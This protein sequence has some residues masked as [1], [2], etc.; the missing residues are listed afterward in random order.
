MFVRVAFGFG[1][2][3]AHI[4]SFPCHW[5]QTSPP[6][7]LLIF[8][9]LLSS[10]RRR[11]LLAFGIRRLPRAPPTSSSPFCPQEI[12]LRTTGLPVL[13][14]NWAWVVGCSP[15]VSWDD[16]FFADLSWICEKGE[17]FCSCFNARVGVGSGDLSFVCV[18][19]FFGMRKFC[20]F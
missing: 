20:V 19:F 14:L 16:R 10:D 17:F 8:F 5:P 6:P 12:E 7:L 4:Y 3:G 2:R 15:A 13:D 11:L 9:L 1:R 18:N